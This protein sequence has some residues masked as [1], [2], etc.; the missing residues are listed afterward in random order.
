MGVSH[1]N[2]RTE[3]AKFKRI[4]DTFATNLAPAYTKP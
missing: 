2:I 3:S 4:E 1:V